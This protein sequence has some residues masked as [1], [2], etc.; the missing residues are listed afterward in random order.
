MALIRSEFQCDRIGAIIFHSPL[1][2]DR[3][4]LVKNDGNAADSHIPDTNSVK[5]VIII[6][7]LIFIYRHTI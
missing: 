3:G 6:K 5:G 1:L 2:S 4:F 7:F